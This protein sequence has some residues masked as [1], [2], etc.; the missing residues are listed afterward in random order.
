MFHSLNIDPKH[1]RHRNHLQPMIELQLYL[2]NNLIDCHHSQILHQHMYMNHHLQMLFHQSYM[3]LHQ[4][5]LGLHSFQKHKRKEH[6]R[7]MRMHHLL[8]MNHIIPMILLSHNIPKMEHLD[9]KHLL[10]N[11]LLSLFELHRILMFQLNHLLM[12]K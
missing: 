2:L 9:K 1:H 12:Y 10:L 6:H 4:Y 11:I 3:L 8:I 5:I 7:L